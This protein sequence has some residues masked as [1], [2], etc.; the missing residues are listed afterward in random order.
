[1][2]F[3][4]LLGER[5][6]FFGTNTNGQKIKAPK[7]LMFFFNF[8]TAIAV[9]WLVFELKS[10]TFNASSVLFAVIFGLVGIAIAFLI[11]YLIWRL[12]WVYLFTTHTAFT[13][14][15]PIVL[16]TICCASSLSN[17]HQNLRSKSVTTE[18]HHSA[19]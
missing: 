6:I 17:R 2:D 7:F 18:N 3:L 8:L 10:I 14:I 12:K 13:I 16:L 5:L 11:M 15:I 1:M 19:N 4:D 9:I